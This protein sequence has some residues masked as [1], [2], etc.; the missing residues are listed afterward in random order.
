VQAIFSPAGRLNLLLIHVLNFIEH[1][2]C[3]GNVDVQD[4]NNE[5]KY[6]V[7]SRLENKFVLGHGA[8]IGV[9]QSEHRNV[10]GQ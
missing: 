9:I 1:L 2:N 3:R 6:V 7:I 5:A 8:S 10:R 4:L